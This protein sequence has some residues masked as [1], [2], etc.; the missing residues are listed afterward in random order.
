MSEK[1]RI[2]CVSSLNFYDHLLQELITKF[3]NEWFFFDVVPDINSSDGESS[4]EG[5]EMPWQ[6]IWLSSDSDLDYDALR[7]EN[8]W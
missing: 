8:N 1:T 4:S 2:H 5:D 3:I 7:R 6:Q